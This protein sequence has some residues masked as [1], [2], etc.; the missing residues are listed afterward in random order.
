MCFLQ[1]EDVP[2]GSVDP[3]RHPRLYPVAL[4][5]G[6]VSSSSCWVQVEKQVA[7]NLPW[8]DKTTWEPEFTLNLTYKTQVRR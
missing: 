4:V 6:A 2:G 8:G 3:H 1:Q 5:V 7:K